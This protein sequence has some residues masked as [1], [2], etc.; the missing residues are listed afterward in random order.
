MDSKELFNTTVCILAYSSSPLLASYFCSDVI[1]FT[2]QHEWLSNRLFAPHPTPLSQQKRG[3]HPES[4]FPFHLGVKVL[5][6]LCDQSFHQDDV[7]N[8]ALSLLFIVSHE[9]AKSFTK[10]AGPSQTVPPAPRGGHYDR[11]EQLKAL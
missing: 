11:D 9:V 10:Q 3:H 8:H 1:Y 7:Q 4:C 5:C 6:A 2:R